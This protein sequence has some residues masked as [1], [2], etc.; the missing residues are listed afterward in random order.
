VLACNDIKRAGGQGWRPSTRRGTAYVLAI[1][2][3]LLVAV[4]A[5]GTLL[6]TR[7]RFAGDADAVDLARVRAAA[8]GAVAVAL[9]RLNTSPT[10][11][12]GSVGTAASGNATIDGLTMRWRIEPTE[13]AE[14]KG[15]PTTLI[16]VQADAGHATRRYQVAAIPARTPHTAFEQAIAV[17]G[18]LG[19]SSGAS[20]TIDATDVATAGTL[21]VTAGGTLNGSVQQVA[22][23]S[24]GADI[25][26]QR[27]LLR[28]TMPSTDQLAALKSAGEELSVPLTGGAITLSNLLLSPNA[29]PYGALSQ[30]GIYVLNAGGRVVTL[31]S[32][33]IVG[34]LIIVNPALGSSI[35]GG[36]LGEAAVPG[37]PCLIVEGALFLNG[38]QPN[39][40]EAVMNFNPQGSPYPFVGGSV[41]SDVN[42]VRVNRFFAPVFVTGSL[43]IAG[44]I[45]FAG[46]VVGGDCA[47]GGTIA[48]SRD[49]WAASSPPAELQASRWRLDRATWSETTP[50][51]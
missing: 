19:I 20:L 41:D 32:V 46:I 25:A 47:I 9:A 7:A 30:R 26:L 38:I 24:S 6:A 34:T 31:T 3:S 37:A 12:G 14:E 49:D 5:T 22:T 15:L 39:L 16:R 1:G 23:G 11:V 33:R 35:G 27:N 2:L 51:S 48:V 45:Q 44:Q 10:F 28:P 4:V 42:D 17:A 21:V 43:A 8:E 29:N 50:G 18:T 13:S 40:N 36:M